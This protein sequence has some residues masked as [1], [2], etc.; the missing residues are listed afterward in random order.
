M[1]SYKY[2]LFL[3]MLVTLFSC[4]QNKKNEQKDI[5]SMNSVV[6]DYDKD[7][8]LALFKQNCY[9]CHSVISASHDEIIAPPI[10]VVKRRYKMRFDSRE[11]FIKAVAAYAFDP[12]TENALMLGAVRI[13]KV[14]PKANFAL[15]DLE[16]IAAYI[17]DHEVEKPQW[18]ESHFDEMH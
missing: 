14:M 15:K 5:E 3:F 9:A 17:Y 10:V 8:A 11:G 7:A 12:K 4:N 6:V 1:N 2:F 13:F 16:L 18:F